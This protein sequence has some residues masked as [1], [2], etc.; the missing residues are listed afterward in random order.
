V[1]VLGF[2]GLYVLDI[3]S[4]QM[5]SPAER[6]KDDAARDERH[7]EVGAKSAAE[8]FVSTA[9][10]GNRTKSATRAVTTSPRSLA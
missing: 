2:I 3:T 7:V 4:Q 1:V 10:T 5:K 9:S 8:A 6:A